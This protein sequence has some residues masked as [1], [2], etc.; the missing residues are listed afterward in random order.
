M[1]TL[2]S[3]MKLMFQLMSINS[4]ENGLP[5]ALNSTKPF[6]SFSTIK[7]SLPLSSIYWKGFPFLRKFTSRHSVLERSKHKKN[8]I[9]KQSSISKIT[10]AISTSST[11]SHILANPAIRFRRNGS[12]YSSIIKVLNFFIVNWKNSWKI[13]A[14]RMLSKIYNCRLSIIALSYSTNTLFAALQMRK[15]SK[16]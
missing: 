11:S 12:S 4:Q 1:Q 7:I 13:T 9:S 15:E 2:N 16:Q 8:S 14:E 6:S 5:I 10:T 3:L